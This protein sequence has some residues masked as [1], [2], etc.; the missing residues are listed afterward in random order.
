[1]ANAILRSRD[2]EVNTPR[3]RRI[4]ASHRHLAAVIRGIRP[5]AWKL[6]SI[7]GDGPIIDSGDDKYFDLLANIETALG[8]LPI[9]VES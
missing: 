1:V 3:D 4:A 8:A 9:G 2:G 5:P 7:V 6:E